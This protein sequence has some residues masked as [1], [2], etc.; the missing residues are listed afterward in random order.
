MR[1]ASVFFGINR[2][3]VLTIAATVAMLFGPTLLILGQA[4]AQTDPLPSWNKGAAKQAI[5]DYVARVTQ[6]GR[7]RFRVA[8]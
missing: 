8:R 4:Q 3:I 7:A 1:S 2:R 5:T 6:Q